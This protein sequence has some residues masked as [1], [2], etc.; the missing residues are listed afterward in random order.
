MFLREQLKNKGEVIRFL[1]QQLAKR[2]NIV[3]RCNHVSS[4][5]IPDKTHC[6][7]LSNHQEVQNNTHEELLLDAS[8]IVN[9][10][11]SVMIGATE[12]RNLTA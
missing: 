3:V 8:V 10:T 9:D 1:P 4:H 12:N 5:E 6:S 11:D 2:Y 7:V